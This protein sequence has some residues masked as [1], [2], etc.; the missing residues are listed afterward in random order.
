MEIVIS[1]NQN[2]GTKLHEMK[3]GQLCIFS[4]S[5][6]VLIV[7]LGKFT[8]KVFDQ[9]LEE[10]SRHCALMAVAPIRR[11]VSN[12]VRRTHASHVPRVKPLYMAYMSAHLLSTVLLQLKPFFHA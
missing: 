7:G 5:I 1:L 4:L 2:F 9:G 3:S 8:T 10:K 6:S 12:E 11:A